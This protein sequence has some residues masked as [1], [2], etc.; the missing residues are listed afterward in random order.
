MWVRRGYILHT[1]TIAA[2]LVTLALEAMGCAAQPAEWSELGAGSRQR[3][4]QQ[5]KHRKGLIQIMAQP[6]REV[7]DLNPDDVVRIMRRI[8][9]TD[10]Q[11]L[12]FGT[13]M[14][15]ALFSS[16]AARVI[17]GKETEA[18][19]SVKGMQVYIGSRSRGN[20]IYDL[21]RGQF[22]TPGVRK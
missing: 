21:G 4:Q 13:D 16:G 6:S 2:L 14:H 10:D 19:L 17:Y 18:L 9:F 11:I 7:A 8:G 12:E 1:V 3:Q 20:F 15:D 5:Q 22:V